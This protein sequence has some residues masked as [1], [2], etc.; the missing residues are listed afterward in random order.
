MLLLRISFTHIPTLYHHPIIICPYPL[1]GI[2]IRRLTTCNTSQGPKATIEYKKEKVKDE[3]STRKIIE[4]VHSRTKDNELHYDTKWLP[5]ESGIN[6]LLSEPIP[7]AGD[8]AVPVRQY[9]STAQE[10]LKSNPSLV[11]T[12]S[13]T[14]NTQPL[15]TAY[16]PSPILSLPQPYGNIA[17]GWS[18][19]IN[20]IQSSHSI[21]KVLDNV[22]ECTANIR[23]TD[24]GGKAWVKAAQKMA[25]Q[26]ETSLKTLRE[27]GKNLSVM[28]RDGRMG[29]DTILKLKD[30]VSLADDS[31]RVARANFKNAQT[32]YDTVLKNRSECQQKINGL[33]QRQASWTEEDVSKF[34]KLLKLEHELKRTESVQEGMLAT[35]ETEVEARLG[36]YTTAM[37]E[38]YH[39]EQIWSDKIRSLSTYGTLIVMGF[40]LF[41]LFLSMAAFEPRKRRNIIEGV[42]IL[43]DEQRRESEQFLHDEMDLIAQRLEDK[44][45]A[46]LLLWQPPTSPVI[47]Q[48]DDY[49]PLGNDVNRLADETAMNNISQLLAQEKDKRE[50]H[51]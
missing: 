26:A 5:G 20:N 23:N 29:Y 11:Y 7:S 39:Q 40:N 14:A 24:Y 25:T 1:L 3:T 12:E 21:E 13:C 4:E 35:C 49:Q 43:M 22:R 41:A 30:N 27:N 44:L 8:K 9:K 32:A 15:P 51:F 6:T 31:F 17:E 18:R 45:G 50:E 19:A 36:A 10:T 33:L 16:T 42:Q 46:T 34:G 37:R 28:V 48:P 38:R 2:Q 47:E